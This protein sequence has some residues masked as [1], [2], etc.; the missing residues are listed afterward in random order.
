[1]EAATLLLALSL[2]TSKPSQSPC[3]SSRKVSLMHR[4][5]A[6]LVWK[7]PEN[8]SFEDAAAIGGVGCETAAL[9]VFFHIVR[10]RTNE[11]GF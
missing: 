5:S 2:N 3:M 11:F 6:K 10:L 7:V 9:Y 4:V 1:M 8:T